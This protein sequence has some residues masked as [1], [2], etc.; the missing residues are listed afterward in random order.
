MVICFMLP[1]ALVAEGCSDTI[2]PVKDNTLIRLILT[3]D[4]RDG[5]YTIVRPETYPPYFDLIN[6]VDPE[7]LK[8][9]LKKDLR[10]S[11]YDVESLVDTLFERNDKSYRLTLASSPEDGYL[12]DYEDRFMYYFDINNPEHERGWERLRE[13]YPTVH[14]I[15]MIGMPAYE[16]ET[17][18]VLAYVGWQFASAGGE[19]HIILYKYEDGQLQELHRLLIGES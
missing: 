9:Y 17:G 18:L 13:D 1:L 11:G 6:H 7:Q 3:R 2:K 12:I 19:Y 5:G 8:D 14:G 15:T 16:P 4:Y 10:Q